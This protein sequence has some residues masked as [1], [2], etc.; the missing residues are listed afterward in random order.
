DQVHR[1]QHRGHGPDRDV[2]EEGDDARGQAV[3]SRPHEHA[4][5]ERGEPEPD[6]E[7]GAVPVRVRDRGEDQAPE[8]VQERAGEQPLAHTPHRP[9]GL[10]AGNL[11]LDALADLG[12]ARGAER[13]CGGHL[14]R[15]L[16]TR[17]ARPPMM[18]LRSP[19][20]IRDAC[21]NVWKLHHYFA[22]ALAGA[23][24]GAASFFHWPPAFAQALWLSLG[25]VVPSLRTQWWVCTAAAL[26]ALVPGAPP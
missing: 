9:F 24:A 4:E 20:G 5:V 1:V 15:T 16:G 25:S 18:V 12:A 21:R 14:G 26:P 3:P 2:D 10:L 6:G 17:H 22:G 11:L 13:I 19:C 8:R 7:D 23:L